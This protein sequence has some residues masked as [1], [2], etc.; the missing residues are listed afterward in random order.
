MR[1]DRIKARRCID[2]KMIGKRMAHKAA[3]N[4]FIGNQLTAIMKYFRRVY[5]D[6]VSS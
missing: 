4:S 1:N 6:T 5:L 3:A 2:G